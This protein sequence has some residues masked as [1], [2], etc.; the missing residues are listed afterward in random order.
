MA[1]DDVRK[2]QNGMRE[3]RIEAERAAYEAVSRMVDKLREIL[4]EGGALQG[5]PNLGTGTRP[6][7]AA[8]MRGNW[9]DNKLPEP[10]SGEEWG[11]AVLVVDRQCRLLKARR[12]R[13]GEVETLPVEPGDIVAQ[14]TPRMATTLEQV[15]VDHLQKIDKQTKRYRQL[16]DFSERMAAVMSE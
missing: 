16:I 5:L 7:Y 10:E 14:D 8:R 15:I 3:A 13:V 1:T 2:R 12:N 11:R 9:I 6:Y 4:G